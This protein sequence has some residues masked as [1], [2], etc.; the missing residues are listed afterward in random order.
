MVATRKFDPPMSRRAAR[1]VVWTAESA[2]SRPMR[3]TLFTGS[4]PSGRPTGQPPRADCAARRCRARAALITTRLRSLPARSRS[5]R[6]GYISGMA[7]EL[8]DL[9]AN[10]E[11]SLVETVGRLEQA[12]MDLLYVGVLDLE[13]RIAALHDALAVVADSLAAGSSLG[14]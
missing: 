10:L 8:R 3:A 6:C 9:M 14:D 5:S 1:E 7:S 12:E 13:A 11:L 2:V 4:S